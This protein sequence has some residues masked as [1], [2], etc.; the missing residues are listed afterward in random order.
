MHKYL[1]HL[2]M[3]EDNCSLLL[4]IIAMMYN[5]AS[6]WQSLMFFVMGKDGVGSASDPMSNHGVR[7]GVGWVDSLV[8]DEAGI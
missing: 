8:A 4:P 2:L 6:C 1:T 3:Q 7:F 5:D